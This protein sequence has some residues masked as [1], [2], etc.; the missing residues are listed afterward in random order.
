MWRPFLQGT[1]FT[2]WADHESWRWNPGFEYATI[3][4]LRYRLRL[5]NL[6][7]TLHI[8]LASNSRRPFPSENHQSGYSFDRRRPTDLC[9]SSPNGTASRCTDH[10]AQE[11][12]IKWNGLMDT[13]SS[14]WGQQRCEGRAPTLQ[15]FLQY[16]A[17]AVFFVATSWENSRSD[18]C[19]VN[20]W[21]EQTT[22]PNDTYW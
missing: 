8:T 22:S 11:R 18:K 21:K 15:T 7:L 16:Q 14:C 13:S 19:W 17:S 9:H 3:L 12:P 10:I 2:I 1:S 5:P 20:H 4:W 6:F